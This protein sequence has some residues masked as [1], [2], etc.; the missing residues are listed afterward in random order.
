MVFNDTII[1]LYRIFKQILEWDEQKL[2]FAK[3]SDYSLAIYKLGR[4]YYFWVFIDGT[5][6]ITCQPVL[7]QQYFYF[8]YKQK[9]DY[10]F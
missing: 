3:I 5:L 10:K 9:Y 7:N 2:I 1:Y 6:N 4:W 8:G